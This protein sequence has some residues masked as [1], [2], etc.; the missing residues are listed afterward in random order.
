MVARRESRR[1]VSPVSASSEAG[2]A[3]PGANS[4][5]ARFAWT[6]AAA[7]LLVALVK[8]ACHEP[9]RDELSDWGAAW[10]ASSFKAFAAWAHYEGLPLGWPASVY[11]FRQ[12]CGSF[13]ALQ[14]L[15]ALLATFA[16]WCVARWAP[17]GRAGRVLFA[18]GF[19]PFHGW[20]VLARPHG[21]TLAAGALACAL[22]SA[23][24]RRPLAL[25]CVLVVLSQ[26]TVYGIVI[27]V[28]VWAAFVVEARLEH[29]RIARSGAVRAPWA[30]RGGML[31]W[32]GA[33]ALLA[34]AIVATVPFL[35]PPADSAYTG[36]WD[37]DLDPS[38]I[39]VTLAAVTDAFFPVRPPSPALPWE[40]RWILGPLVLIAAT[41]I[42]ARRPG[43]FV[44]WSLSGTGLV[45][46]MHALIP[47]AARHRGYLF[48]AFFLALWLTGR[49]ASE[50]ARAAGSSSSAGA[51]SWWT[52]A[53]AVATVVLLA[54]Q[55]PAGLY[56]AA[57]DLRGT[58]SPIR[59]VAAY[60]HETGL[61]DHPLVGEPGWATAPIGALLE[62]RVYV[63]ASGRATA[64]VRYDS[65]LHRR[66]SDE[67]LVGA[68]RDLAAK[69]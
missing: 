47:G 34:V 62:R 33:T 65:L 25:A 17:L 40:G 31:P 49:R 7:F 56:I 18:L 44:V 66:V 51:G 13:T 8:A 67:E 61:D 26:T 15:H 38:H 58:F 4:G 32:I 11:L 1:P 30:D 48:F 19:L 35:M 41:L 53:R 9:W 59:E 68:A 29:P 39:R 12:V 69:A 36:S 50:E 60:L 23:R 54:A 57:R 3:E 10:E 14:Y 6:L 16:V 42:A 52:R 55:V 22:A 43:G 20:G 63:P 64:A 21:L 27:A 45:I 5:E 28:A 46:F 37:F 24:P 2:A